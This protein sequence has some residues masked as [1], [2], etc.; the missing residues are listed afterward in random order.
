MSKQWRDIK[1]R[2][3]SLSKGS[4]KG[5]KSLGKKETITNKLR[6]FLFGNCHLALAGC[7]KDRIQASLPSQLRSE[8][9]IDNDECQV[10]LVTTWLIAE[11]SQPFDLQEDILH[12]NTT[13]K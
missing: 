6:A 12:E 1:V 8:S 10:T 3:T 13:T 11:S 4:S 5:N 9:Q 7:T 2:G